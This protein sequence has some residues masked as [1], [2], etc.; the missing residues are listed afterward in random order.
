MATEVLIPREH[1]LDRLHISDSTERRRRQRGKNWPAHVMVGNRILYSESSVNRWIAT[2]EA[3]NTGADMDKD[4]GLTPAVQVSIER[5]AAELA[6][7]APALTARQ[8]A[9]LRAIFANP[10]GSGV[11]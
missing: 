10:G 7:A 2:Q 1:V 9:T 6:E 3:A 4:E 5:R 11:R 8:I